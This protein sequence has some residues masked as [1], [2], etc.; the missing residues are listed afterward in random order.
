MKKLIIGAVSLC[1]LT[2]ACKKEE[3]TIIPQTQNPGVT[4]SVAYFPLDSGS[5]WVYE[6]YRID[7]LGMETY[8]NNDSTFITGDT[9]I[10]GN[11]Y[12]ILRNI[13]F[14]PLVQYCRDSA[15]CIVNEKGEI[16]FS[17]NLQGQLIRTDS[18]FSTVSL[19][20][21]V[22]DSMDNGNFS[23]SL[24]SNTYNTLQRST[25]VQ[26]MFTQLPQFHSPYLTNFAPGVGLVRN[27]YIY[28][29]SPHL[30]YERRLIRY[31]IE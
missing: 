1:L 12:S 29:S 23:L 22:R 27:Q 21:I 20:I 5:Y 17:A 4:Q 28:S 2:V 16:I 30:L 10:G 8:N 15:N 26:Y 9:I 18:I 3:D 11:T 19:F 13:G 31:H 25:R 7:T 6:H 14:Y 24:N